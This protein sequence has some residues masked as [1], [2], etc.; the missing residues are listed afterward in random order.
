MV[1]DCIDLV[2]V[3]ASISYYGAAP[4]AEAVQALHR[5]SQYLPQSTQ[6]WLTVVKIVS[7]IRYDFL[8]SSLAYAR[9]GPCLR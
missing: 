9:L 4:T 5:V 1:G 3:A 8:N 2:C 7:V 6:R